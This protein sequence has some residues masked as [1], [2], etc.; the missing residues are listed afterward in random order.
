[1]PPEACARLVATNEEAA[2]LVEPGSGVA[3]LV[4]NAVDGVPLAAFI[5]RLCSLPAVCEPGKP[6]TAGPF[7]C[8][9]LEAGESYDFEAWKPVDGAGVAYNLSVAAGVIAEAP[10]GPGYPTP[11]P[12]P[13]A[14]SSRN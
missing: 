4:G 10:Y 5:C 9:R 1:M 2:L 13:G 11:S 8:L 6:L 3:R 7:E 14:A 12:A